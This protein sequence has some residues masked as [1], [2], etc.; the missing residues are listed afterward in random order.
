MYTKKAGL[1]KTRKEVAPITTII[2]EMMVRKASTSLMKGTS[3]KI[4]EAVSIEEEAK[5]KTMTTNSEEMGE[6]IIRITSI[7][8]SNM[9]TIK[10]MRMRTTISLLHNH[11]ITN[12]LNNIT[13]SSRKS[14]VDIMRKEAE[15]IITIITQTKGMT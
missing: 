6:S 12:L 8:D 9:M 11:P 13:I 4:E 5:I 1:R 10:N 2:Q 15:V 3:M 7:R 14:R